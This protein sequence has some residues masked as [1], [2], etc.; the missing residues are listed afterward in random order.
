MLLFA[1]TGFA[2]AAATAITGAIN[3]RKDK[4]PWFVALGRY[5]DV[6]LLM[7]GAMLPD[8]IDKPVGDYLF[9]KTFENGRIFSHTLLFLILL[10]ASGLILYRAKHQVWALTLAA[11]DF[12]HLVLDQMWGVPQTLFWPLMGWQ[13]PF[14]A[15]EGFAWSIWDA[16]I[17]NPAV[18]IPE[19][20]GLAILLWYGVVALKR[21]QVGAVLKAGRIS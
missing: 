9:R 17:S 8:I 15:I 3:S 6:R 20:I 19:A 5:L 12:M 10:T 7:V 11:G 13:F 18:Y 4:L 2:L 21:K 16:L 14:E 1:H